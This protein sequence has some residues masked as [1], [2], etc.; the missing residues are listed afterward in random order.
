MP[1]SQQIS[2]MRSGK[3][4]PLARTG[5]GVFMLLAFLCLLAPETAWADCSSHPVTSR[6]DSERPPTLIDSLIDD[7]GARTDPLQAPPRRCTGVWC[8]GQPAIP[9]TPVGVFEWGMEPWAWWTFDPG[10]SSMS[11]TF[12]SI[13]TLR[14]RPLFCGI[15][16]FH[17]PRCLP[18]A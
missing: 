2:E 7:L 17:P 14:L 6:G 13:D 18:A 1:R 15:A 8:T 3:L 10:A 5:T 11:S 16:V 9:A 12:R 4:K